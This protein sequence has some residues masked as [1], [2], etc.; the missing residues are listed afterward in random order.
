MRL[1]NQSTKILAGSEFSCIFLRLSFLNVFIGVSQKLNSDAQRQ[2]DSEQAF[3][4]HTIL[5]Y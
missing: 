3:D 2:L 4:D 5:I 1:V